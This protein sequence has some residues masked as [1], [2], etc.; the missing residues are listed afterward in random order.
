MNADGLKRNHLERENTKK[1]KL[2]VKIKRSPDE[3]HKKEQMES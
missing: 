2:T 1:G 3:R